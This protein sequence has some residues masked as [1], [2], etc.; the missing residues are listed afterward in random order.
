MWHPAAMP[1]TR[2]MAPALVLS[3]SRPAP[4]QAATAEPIV[5]WDSLSPVNS[6]N[7]TADATP[8]GRQSVPALD[9]LADVKGALKNEHQLR[10]LLIYVHIPFCSSKCTFCVW[11]AGIDTPQLRSPDEVRARYVQAL[12]AQIECLAPYLA[13]IGYVPRCVY[14]GGGTPSILTPEQIETIGDALQKN[15]DLSAVTEYSVESSPETLTAEKIRAFQAAG[16]N[17]LSIGVQSFDKAELRRAG[18]AHSPE[19]AQHAVRTA[20]EQGCAN[21]NIDMI[22]G[23]PKQTPETLASTL[24]TLLTLQP[25]HV[26][27]YTYVAIERTVMAGQ[28]R[29]GHLPGTSAQ[30][31]AAA[32]DLAHRTLAA[33]GYDEYMSMYYSIRPECT[34]A[35]E[36]YYFDWHGDYA[37]FGSGAHSV[38]GH[39]L[40]GNKRGRLAEFIS[41]PTVSDH[42]QK[43]G[44][45]LALDASFKLL[46]LGRRLD[47]ERF[48]SKFGFNVDAVLDHREMRATRALLDRLER[49]LVV[50]S[51]EAYVSPPETGWHGGELIR[52]TDMAAS[53]MAAAR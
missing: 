22:T 34:F 49:P 35:G 14:W 7:Q 20:R 45:S 5:R 24:S 25:E 40:M 28:M 48:W 11:V 39:H 17:R 36:S 10:P 32:Q 21:L 47:F 38:L 23:F 18:R 29:R 50:T 27:C 16:M 1:G 37:G 51:T 31:R 13:D 33:K 30:Q 12:T 9:A 4:G 19:D 46:S 52:L 42:H 43:M 15:F 2:G 26:T 6:A 3:T 53:L 44:V 8:V 41:S